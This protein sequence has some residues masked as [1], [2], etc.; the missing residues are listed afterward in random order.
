MSGKVVLERQVTQ[1][2]Q[3]LDLKHLV[4]GLYIVEVFLNDEIV[5]KLIVVE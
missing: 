1:N 4:Q 2:N 5:R 3:V